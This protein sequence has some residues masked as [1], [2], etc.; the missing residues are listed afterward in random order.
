MRKQELKIIAE[1]LI[2]KYKQEYM[3]NIID[4]RKRAHEILKRNINKADNI[5]K[6]YQS[7]WESQWCQIQDK[8]LLQNIE[9]C[10][11]KIENLEKTENS[12]LKLIQEKH[13]LQVF[14]DTM[15]QTINDR[16]NP[17]NFDE[18]SP[19]IIVED[20]ECNN[21]GIEDTEDYY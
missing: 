6:D 16:F 3:S 11:N 15:E 14:L 2:N 5:V 8:I 10:I 21:I 9:N 4:L 18:N 20:I 17:R 12:D 19:N 7:E 13:K 1:E